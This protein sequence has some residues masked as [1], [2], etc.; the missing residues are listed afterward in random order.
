M[1]PEIV[2]VCFGCRS[3]DRSSGACRNLSCNPH[4][5]RG[6]RMGED[7][8]SFGVRPAWD[9][10]ILHWLNANFS[11]PTAA[12]PGFRGIILGLFLLFIV[13]IFY[14]IWRRWDRIRK[15]VFFPMAALPCVMLAIAIPYFRYLSRNPWDMGTGQSFFQ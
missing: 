2:C 8:L 5:S 9:E 3:H 11:G 10:S 13:F 15:P 1:F 6:F 12:L 4:Q 7:G 14:A